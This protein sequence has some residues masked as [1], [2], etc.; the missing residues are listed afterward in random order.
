MLASFM[1][2][3]ASRVRSPWLKVAIASSMRRTVK[4]A[5]AS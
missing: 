5:W 2:R 4:P 1:R 3:K